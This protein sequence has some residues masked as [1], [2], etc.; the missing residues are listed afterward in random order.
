MQ[1]K[2]IETVC[3]YSCSDCDHLDAECRGCNPL[4][5]KPFWTQFVGIEKCPIFECC[6]EMR[7]LPHCGRCPDLICERFTRFKDPGMN[8][9]EAKA[10]LLRM[11]KELRSRK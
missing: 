3:G 11:E 1:S 6:V 7:K 9:E 8:D 5:G 4:R 10:G 2:K